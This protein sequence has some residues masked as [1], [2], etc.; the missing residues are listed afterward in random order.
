MSRALVT[1]YAFLRIYSP[2]VF[3]QKNSKTLKP[4]IFYVRGY[5]WNDNIIHFWQL[6]DSAGTAPVSFRQYIISEGT[7]VTRWQRDGNAAK[8]A[9]NS[10]SRTF[11]PPDVATFRRTPPSAMAAAAATV[12]TA[13]AVNP[14][15]AYNVTVTV[16]ATVATA[17][18]VNLA[19]VYNV[20]TTV[21]ATN[22]TA[23][24]V[25]LTTVY[26][27]TTDD[28]ET[29]SE[30]QQMSGLYEVPALLVIIL[31]VLYGSIS[32]IAVAGNGLVIWAIVT[33]NRMRS[34]TNHYL[35]NLAFA[36]ILIALFAVPFEVSSRA[37]L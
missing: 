23:L 17:F 3:G 14:T 28:N 9:T 26:N 30:D 8:P 10:G 25:N 6:F 32:V 37:W 7:N 4:K 33:S 29:L 16:A 18:A 36:D 20:T 12:A 22:A 31:S 27:A 11:W 35:A 34:V 13:V 19:T 21:I 1:L 5:F 15:T 2:F 24:A